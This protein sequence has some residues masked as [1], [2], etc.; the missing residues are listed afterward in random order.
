MVGR[1]LVA[2]GAALI[3]VLMP[4]LIP[5]AIGDAYKAY[6]DA[7]S[8]GVLVTVINLGAV[9]VLLISIWSLC[10]LKRWARSFSMWGTVIGIVSMPSTGPIVLFGWAMMLL[11]IGITLW[12]VA[13]TMAFFSDL[14]RHFEPG[15]P[16]AG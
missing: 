11:E 15:S 5:A 13:L 1:V 2:L 16:E 7:A 8:E 14:K 6:L 4:S 3:D 9:I 12:T 10:T